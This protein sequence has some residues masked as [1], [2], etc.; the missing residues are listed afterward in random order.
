[1]D[2]V[3]RGATKPGFRRS[4]PAR[5][6]A[7][8]VLA[9][10]VFAPLGFFDPATRLFSLPPTNK[11]TDYVMLPLSLFAIGY[12]MGLFYAFRRLAKDTSGRV[13]PH[14]PLIILRVFAWSVGVAGIA[15]ALGA[16]WYAPTV[17]FLES[18]V[19]AVSP[20]IFLPPIAGRIVRMGPRRDGTAWG[21][22]LFVAAVGT[23][24]LIV[25]FWL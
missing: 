11:P 20:A 7:I 6:V 2:G 10:L 1:M 9:G 5:L 16:S 19:A 14:E 4:R 3:E 22:L 24:L 13:E 18:C 8:A 23:P 25:A 17:S 12:F 21:M 15:A